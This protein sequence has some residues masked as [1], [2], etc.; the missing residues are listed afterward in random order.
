M[1][2]GRR[3]RGEGVG[4]DFVVCG[5]GEGT[6]LLLLVDLTG[7]VRLLRSILMMPLLLGPDG[8]GVVLLARSW[9][10]WWPW[11]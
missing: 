11:P 1:M 9:G 4:G 6:L 3:K 7:V 5:G 10:R 2:M 8:W